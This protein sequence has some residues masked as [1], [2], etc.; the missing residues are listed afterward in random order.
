MGTIARENFPWWKEGNAVKGLASERPRG[1]GS[2]R[3]PP[4]PSSGARGAQR[5]RSGAA[6]GRP[7]ARCERPEP[8]P[9]RAE[10]VR[11]YAGSA[12]PA[13][14]QRAERSWC[15]GVR[16]RGA[17]LA[18]GGA[19]RLR[20]SFAPRARRCVGRR[21]APLTESASGQLLGYPV[22]DKIGI[23][24]VNLELC[25]ISSILLD[26]G[27]L[28]CSVSRV[29]NELWKPKYHSVVLWHSISHP[30]GAVSGHSL[31][32]SVPRGARKA[33]WDVSFPQSPSSPR[34]TRFPS[35]FSS[36][37]FPLPEEVSHVDP[38]HLKVA[39]ARSHALM[40]SFPAISKMS[41]KPI[42]CFGLKREG[43]VF[44]SSVLGIPGISLSAC[45]RTLL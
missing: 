13:A 39:A 17:L 1:P 14:G 19:A 32:V 12:Q 24:C 7:C 23:C 22:W 33:C 16:W 20:E 40:I 8:N 2:F 3:A 41:F 4:S 37:L 31:R 10:R 35:F 21:W 30:V 27:V 5:L 18:P 15:R 6:A 28:F 26:A 25:A 36:W 43:F 9:R 29:L 45:C 42:S 44:P 34:F 38:A 11:V